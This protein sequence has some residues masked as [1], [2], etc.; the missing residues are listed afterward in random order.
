MRI[1]GRVRLS[2][3]KEESTSVERQRELIEQYANLHDHTIVGWAEDTDVSGSVSPFDTPGLGP[4]L[5]EDKRDEWDV[6]V[7]WR[8][9]RLSRRVIALNEMFGWMLE[10]NKTLV[11]MSE[12]LDL[13]NW[14]GRLVA[15]VIAGVAEGEL[16]AIKERTKASRK[17]LLE[18]GRWPGGQVPFGLTPVEL[19]GGGYRLGLHPEE[20]PVVRE[21]VDEV[22]A[23]GAV[24][25]VA[26]DRD[27]LPST[28][29]K[30]LTAKYLLGHATYERQTVRDAE[31]KPVL[32]AEPILTQD[33]WDQLQ[34]AL[35]ARRRG[36]HRT[37]D[38]APLNGVVQC[39]VCDENL[40]HKIYHR[41]Y[42]KKLYRYYHCR[43]KDHCAQVDAE[44]VEEQVAD[45][46]LNAVG[47]L[48]V[49]ERV[50]RQAEDHSAAL[51]DA[52][53][54]VD[55]L[56]P[57]LGTVTSNLMKA[58][59]TG[60]LEALDKRIAELEKL[61]VTSAGWELKDTGSTFKSVWDISS[62]DDRRQLLLRSG[63]RFKI[64][65]ISGTQAIQS[66]LYVPEEIQDLLN[67]KKPLPKR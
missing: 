66:E 39:F 62:Q 32:N 28:L 57:L 3:F 23:G 13:S 36:P 24:E 46:F 7:V 12:S 25:K 9:D 11:S 40:F 14:V 59:L 34:A 50:Y 26:V 27:T 67:A 53:R 55:E 17:R 60:Q 31:G 15:N 65:R 41:D 2:R 18:T 56:T 33:K 63:I 16:E 44:M 58:R 19:P 38:T 8:L 52:V 30:M 6:L 10:H 5:C 54:A 22:I 61:P 29:W 43:V 47:D 37:Y 45:A 64:Q 21:I 1:L 49:Q 48:P 51:E 4:W 35:E 20:A 42:G